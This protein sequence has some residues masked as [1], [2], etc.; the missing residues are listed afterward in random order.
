MAATFRPNFYDG[1]FPTRTAAFKSLYAADNESIPKSEYRVLKGTKS[2]LIIVVT[3]FT[4][5]AHDSVN[6]LLAAPGVRA[7]WSYISLPNPSD[8]RFALHRN[9]K[10][11]TFHATTRSLCDAAREVIAASNID[12][13]D[14]RIAGT[15]L[16]ARYAVS[17]ASEADCF[18]T[19]VSGV[20]AVNPPLDL[21]F[22]ADKLDYW[23]MRDRSRALPA[24]LAGVT[25]LFLKS[26]SFWEFNSSV[27]LEE[28]A[29]HGVVRRALDFW[30]AP[31]RG[32]ARAL[33]SLIARNFAVRLERMS[34]KREIAAYESPSEEFKFANV[35][36]SL[37]EQG[38]KQFMAS[39]EGLRARN[40]HV[41]ILHSRDDFLNR[42]ADLEILASTAALDTVVLPDGGHTGAIFQEA[43]Q[44]IINRFFD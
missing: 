32:N 41:R 21:R 20:L 16:G 12:A 36:P 28:T 10:N 31:L 37:D 17:M 19:P 2:S 3:G 14:I 4:G 34:R 23:V 39:V 27:D 11:P 25:I 38:F 8:W 29:D 13:T 35:I 40:R 9:S 44:T 30:I 42:P 5:N 22:A 6:D 7:G 15:S 33:E 26:L 43:G 1:K 18:S 24:Q